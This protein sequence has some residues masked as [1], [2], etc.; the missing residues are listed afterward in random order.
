MPKQQQSGKSKE[1]KT[2]AHSHE[3][4]LRPDIGTE[5]HFQKKK[6]P[7]TYRYDSSLSPSLEWDDNPTREQAEAEI[8]TISNYLTEL[9]VQLEKLNHI[10]S[11]L[12]PEGKKTVKEIKEQL[13]QQLYKAQESLDKLKSM[14]QPFLNWTGKAERLSFD[15]PTL[16]LFIH[17][18]I[19][20]RAIIETLRTHKIGTNNLPLFD[21]FSDPQWSITD[22]IL[23]AYEYQGDWVNRMILG[24][25]LIVMNSLLQY[26]GLGGQ[27]QMIY[28]DPPYGIKFG[29][30]FQPFVRKRDVKHNDD[31]DFTREPE[32]V[33][34]YRDTWELGLHSYLTY[35]RDRLLL[36]REL[37]TDSGSIFVQISDENVHHVRELMDEVFGRENFV[38]LITF[39][40]GSGFTSKYLKTTCDYLLWY[41]KD[42]NNTKFKRIFFNK[43]S[44]SDT[45]FDKCELP[46]GSVIDIKKNMIIPDK[47]KLLTYRPLVSGAFSQSTTF[48]YEFNGKNYHP[49]KNRC[50]KTTQKGLDNLAREKRIYASENTLKFVVYHSDFPLEEISHV[51]D[52]TMELIGKNYVVQTTT[53]TIQRCLLMTTD[54]GDLVLDPTCGSGTTAYVAEQ[55]GRRWIT[56]DVS[57]VPL[58][59]AR[60]RLLTATFPWYQLQDG[61][62]PA[63]GFI[64][65]RKRNSKGEEI[66]GIVPHITL[67]S[68]ANNEPPQEE[69]LVDRP[70]EDKNTVRVS[71]PFTIEGTIPPP[72]DMEDQ[73]VPATE[74][75][76]TNTTASFTDRM[77]E[78]LRRSPKLHLPDNK[79]VTFTSV[80]Q[81]ARSQNLSAE[82][83]VDDKPVAFLF[84]PEN[85][86]ISERAVF[87]SAEEAQLKNYIHFYVI[88][89]AITPN[90]RQLVENC[91]AAIGIP[92]TYIQ[93]TP[94]LLM[95]DLL[96]NMRSSQI[97]SVCGLPEIEITQN[98]EGKYQV[99]LLGLDVF[100]PVTMDVDHRQGK[101]VPAWFLDTNY[102][103]L[104]FYVR[105]AFFP[106]TSAWDSIKKGLKGSY[107]DSVWE[108]LAGTTSAP[109]ADGEHKQ[110][111]VKVIDDRGNELLV[112]RE[113]K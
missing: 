82:A 51:W 65:K 101:N 6:P 15:V 45:Y 93:A 99:E 21:L 107:E 81:P 66:G 12:D 83:M 44:G 55:W 50:W 96:K 72:A 46:D 77:L 29:S 98:Q 1:A 23:K 16:P 31:D 3:H 92:A 86:A 53:K 57:R 2:Y 79:T 42:S 24:D 110:I 17:E 54:P 103:G 39:K 91:Q 20:T 10:E 70:E 78:V 108:H 58:A 97:F 69:I 35:L 109:F 104:C 13:T 102:N 41:S 52:D 106:R 63:G 64:Y 7:V 22:Q 113:L 33:Q 26:E 40:T 90:A 67:K 8:N 37:L 9:S 88:G 32:M 73:G 43:P 105:Q 38:S 87:K 74:A 94:D 30:N 80:R 59:L 18:R 61:N 48:D 47:A 85:G 49:G 14:S 76:E 25:S 68:I 28:M 89:F 19:S 95:G 75:G 5:S 4:P 71:S 36:A 27:V 112:V 84:G 34:A 56:C 111:A 100:D 60:Q 62:S 11:S